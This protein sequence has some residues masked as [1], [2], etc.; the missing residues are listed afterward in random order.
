MNTIITQDK[1]SIALKAFIFIVLAV[2]LVLLTIPAIQSWYEG[3]T[4]TS[5]SD[6]MNK[7]VC[8]THTFY[9]QK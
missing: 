2:W 5:S 1:V 9:T 7:N 4:V 6:E 8:R 3:C